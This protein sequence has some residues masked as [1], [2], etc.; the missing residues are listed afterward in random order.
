MA[1]LHS[2]TLRRAGWALVCLAIHAG[3]V[4]AAR[5]AR[6]VDRPPVEDEQ[7]VAVPAPTPVPTRQPAPAAPSL[8]VLAVSIQPAQVP[9]GGQA[10]LVVNY[11]VTDPAG[12]A[13][14]VEERRALVKD[15]AT[16]VQM[17]DTLTRAAGAHTSARPVRV[18]AD[19]APGIYT[20]KVVLVAAG[21]QAEGT[22]L[23]EVR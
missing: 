21:V 6:P 13:V 5:P 15:G 18:P 12:T 19:A 17:S 7:L 23:F 8:K 9:R 11:S 14:A 16:I 20:F 22:A 1:I 2:R 10:D 3:C 4:A